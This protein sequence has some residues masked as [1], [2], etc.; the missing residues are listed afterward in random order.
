[1]EITWGDADG[2]MVGL[3]DTSEVAGL[4]M[5]LTIRRHKAAKATGL[6]VRK[7]KPYE[8]AVDEATGTLYLRQYRS[9]FWGELP[10][11]LVLMIAVIFALLSC[12]RYIQICTGVECRMRQANALQS[13]YWILRDEN[14]LREKEAAQISD[15]NQVYKIATEELG[16]VP[17]EKAH[18]LI[19]ERSNSEFVY[20]TDNIPNFVIH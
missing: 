9:P 2:R 12:C 14:T 5:P 16:M 18:V 15:L 6:M 11:V 1:M 4:D 17:V 13:E 8:F 3:I 7:A 19:Y 10:Y 20:Q